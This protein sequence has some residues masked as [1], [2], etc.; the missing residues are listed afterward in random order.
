MYKMCLLKTKKSLVRM[1]CIRQQRTFPPHNFIASP[2]GRHWRRVF[3]CE[4]RE[5]AVFKGNQPFSTD[6]CDGSHSTPA[7]T[8]DR[9]CCCCSQGTKQHRLCC[10][11]RL[12]QPIK[13]P[14]VIVAKPEQNAA[15]PVALL[16]F[17]ALF[18]VLEQAHVDVYSDKLSQNS[19]AV[20]KSRQ[21]PLAPVPN[22]PTIYVDVKKHLNNNIFEAVIVETESLR[23][24][25]GDMG[26]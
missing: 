12:N 22:K 1:Y 8:I 20:W 14:A 10:N 4:S 2:N 18:V 21:P 19:G 15:L 6:C 17:R 11:F 25:R 5:S 3:G 16:L 23:G 24:T 13:S 9:H 26:Y 7:M